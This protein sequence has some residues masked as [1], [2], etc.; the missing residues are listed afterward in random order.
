MPRVLPRVQQKAAAFRAYKSHCPGV[1]SM[2]RCKAS[3]GQRAG[4]VYARLSSSAEHDSTSGRWRWHLAMPIIASTA[5]KGARVCDLV[6]CRLSLSPPLLKSVTASMHARPRS[7]TGDVTM[8][9]I[10]TSDLPRRARIGIHVRAGAAFWRSCSKQAHERHTYQISA[11]P[12]V[13][14]LQCSTGV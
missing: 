11:S 14:A 3:N 12:R 6:D 2:T 9:C 8:G 10:Q 7:T 4:R 5:A 1:N 13:D